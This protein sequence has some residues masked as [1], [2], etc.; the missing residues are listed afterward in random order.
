M[1]EE[2]QKDKKNHVALLL[3]DRIMDS[4]D[5]LGTKLLSGRF[6]AITFDTIGYFL[7]VLFC[8]LL[9]IKGT[10]HIETFIAILSTYALLV[11]KTR[12]NYFNMTKTNGG[13][14]EKIS[15]VTGNPADPGSI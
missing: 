9:T 11:Q 7:G 2:I 1:T 6:L 12:E 4:L 5:G 14:N 15:P 10:L 13:S 8:G 3:I